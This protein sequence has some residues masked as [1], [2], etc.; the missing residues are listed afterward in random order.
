LPITRIE[1]FDL[2]KDDGF[3]KKRG[4]SERMRRQR[5]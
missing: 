4:K 2:L 5:W 3:V 1:C